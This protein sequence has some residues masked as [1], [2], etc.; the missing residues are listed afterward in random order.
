MLQ[1]PNASDSTHSESFSSRNGAQT[2]SRQTSS[3]A[4]DTAEAVDSTDTS[5]TNPISPYLTSN[6]QFVR[7]QVLSVREDSVETHSSTDA[8]VV[9]PVTREVQAQLQDLA[10]DPD[11]FHAALRQAFGDNYDFQAAESIRQQTLAGDFSWMPEIR[12]V[13]GASLQDQSGTQSSGVALGAYSAETDTI[14]ISRELLN[15]DPERATQIL[16]EEVGHALDARLNDADSA[17]DEGDIF[18]HAVRGDALSDTELAELQAENDSGTILVDGQEVE[19]EYGLFSFVGDAF[20]AIGDAFESIGDAFTGAIDGVLDAIGSVVD[21]VIDFAKDLWDTIKD[22]VIEILNSPLFNA[23]L[24]IAQFVPI[25]I[26]QLVVRIVQIVKA[27]YQIYQGVKHGSISMVLS[28]V[29]G[30]ASGA[31]TVGGALGASQG[32]IDTANQVASYARTASQ[33]HSAIAQRDFGAALSLMGDAFADT[34]IEPALRFASRAADVQAAAEDGDIL[35]AISLGSGLIAD[36]PGDQGD[37]WLN[38]LSENTAAVDGI[39]T[40]IE[41][42]DYSKAASMLID[43]FGDDLSLSEATRGHI[44]DVATTYEKIDEA[45]TLIDN[46]DY[47]GA[48]LLLLDTAAN[49][50]PTEGSKE[51]LREIAKTVGEIGQVA[52]LIESGDYT[53]ALSKT[54]ELLGNPL[55]PASQA[56]IEKLEHVATQLQAVKAAVDSGNPD[57]AVALLVDLVGA[58]IPPALLDKFFG[59]VDIAQ[60]I[61]SLKDAIDSGEFADAADIASRLSQT[62]GNESLAAVFDQLANLWRDGV[63]IVGEIGKI[64]ELID[65]GEYAQAASRTAELLGTSLDPTSQALIENLQQLATQLQAIKAAVD[66]GDAEQAVALLLEL[67]DADIPPALLE[68]IFGAADVAQDFALLKEAIESGEFADAADIASRLSQSAGNENLATLFDQL[69]NLL[70][71]GIEISVQMPSI[72]PDQQAA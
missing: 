17:G 12:V 14:Y 39:V 66:S 32:F 28:G 52:E 50:A 70:R 26:V 71:N 13:D 10:Q 72:T 56:L 36:I 65:S 18:A 22:T 34:D 20:D 3:A 45:R 55:D 6:D 16:T 37:D 5:A 30:V 1:G 59:A 33:A 38:A 64:E 57:Q 4:T 27:A 40:A 24:T 7:E 9:D 67:T 42:G 48:A 29:A 43:T 47:S 63:R 35:G 54:A 15:S 46:G 61:E 41:T 51:T 58:D 2:H 8:E 11:A 19:V 44:R 60:D 25:P 23:I 62:V 31:A 53:Q 69:A 68:K 21:T 49:V